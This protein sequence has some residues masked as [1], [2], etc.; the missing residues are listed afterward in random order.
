MAKQSKKFI[1]YKQSLLDEDQDE[2]FMKFNEQNLWKTL[3]LQIYPFEDKK[4]YK[5]TITLV[6]WLT[7]SGHDLSDVPNLTAEADWTKV[8][9][10]FIDLPYKTIMQYS[11]EEIKMPE[12]NL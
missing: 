9:P 8:I 6:K 5:E 11:E 12:F 4:L 10:E 3:I 1:Q 7:L 2:L